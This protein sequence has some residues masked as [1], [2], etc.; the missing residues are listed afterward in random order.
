MLQHFSKTWTNPG[1][2]FWHF[3]IAAAL[4]NARLERSSEALAQRLGRLPKHGRDDRARGDGDQAYTPD[5]HEG[6][7]VT[8]RPWEKLH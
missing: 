6:Q 4:L 5:H 1:M 3:G 8:V 7:Q 2:H